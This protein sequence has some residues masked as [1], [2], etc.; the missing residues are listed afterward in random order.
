MTWEEWCSSEYNT[1]NWMLNEPFNSNSEITYG[2]EWIVD[3]SGT[4]IKGT[5]IIINN[6]EYSVIRDNTV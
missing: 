1:Y 6:Y 3:N 5:D 4:R 2:D